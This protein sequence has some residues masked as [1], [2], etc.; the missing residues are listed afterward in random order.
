[1]NSPQYIAFKEADK[2]WLTYKADGKGWFL[3]EGTTCGFEVATVNQYVEGG[4]FL[5]SDT[6]EGIN[7]EIRKRKHA[8]K[9]GWGKEGEVG[10][11]KCGYKYTFDYYDNNDGYYTAAIKED[12]TQTVTCL[13][14]CKFTA[15]IKVEV[16]FSTEIIKT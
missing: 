10:C 9:Y 4:K 6:L 16:T 11:P 3:R 15:K 14:G 1:M 5:K 8:E 12:F 7:E 2:E 13:C